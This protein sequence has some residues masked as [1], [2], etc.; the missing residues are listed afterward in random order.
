MATSAETIRNVA[1]FAGAA[2]RSATV[3]D[4]RVARTRSRAQL[5]LF[6]KTTLLVVASLATL[7]ALVVASTGIIRFS[8]QEKQTGGTHLR[9]AVPAILIPVGLRLIPH[10]VWRSQAAQLQPWMPVVK[11]AADALRKSP[12]GTYV[13]VRSRSEYVNVAKRA[14]EMVID[15]DDGADAVH[16]AF[17]VYLAGSVAHRL[18]AG[19]RD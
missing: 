1:I 3:P 4:A 2:P 16:I 7:G 10:D 6:W 11:A 18:E 19:I 8:I 12:D 14:G 13:E 5:A 9:L 17:P 15:V